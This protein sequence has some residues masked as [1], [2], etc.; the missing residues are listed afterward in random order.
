MPGSSL[1]RTSTHLGYIYRISFSRAT[2]SNKEGSSYLFGK[3]QGV[4][5]WSFGVGVSRNLKSWRKVH[6][7]ILRN[8]S[9][10]DIQGREFTLG[11]FLKGHILLDSNFWKSVLLSYES[12]ILV[13]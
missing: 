10:Y 5:T 4:E 13:K 1:N 11:N 2:N 6:E 12:V 8:K 9:T 3:G 7:S